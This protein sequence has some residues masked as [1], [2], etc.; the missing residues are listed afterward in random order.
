M[1]IKGHI[2]TIS[3]NIIPDETSSDFTLVFT[4]TCDLEMAAT[5]CSEDEVERLITHL[6]QVLN[7]RV[8]LEEI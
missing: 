2:G 5:S 8:K 7:K 3:Y 1:E 4:D 6:A